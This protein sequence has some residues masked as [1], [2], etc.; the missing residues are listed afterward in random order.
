MSTQVPGK[1]IGIYGSYIGTQ[2]L[3][4]T[5]QYNDPISYLYVC[6]CNTIN[7]LVQI[8]VTA[9]KNGWKTGGTLLIKLAR[10]MTDDKFCFHLL[11]IA[12]GSLIY[13]NEE[14]HILN[15]IYIK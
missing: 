7:D 14:L 5:L 6:G 2:W 3:G 9:F 11:S 12:N 8:I 13:K 4:S 1:I 10:W 15:G